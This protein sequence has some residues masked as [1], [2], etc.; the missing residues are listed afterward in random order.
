MFYIIHDDHVGEV[1]RKLLTEKMQQGVRVYFLYDGLGSL[2][3][4]SRYLQE[5]RQAGAHVSSFNE[6]NGVSKYLHINFRNHRKILIIDGLKAFVGSLNLGREYLGEDESMGYWRDTHVMLQGPSVQATQ[7]VFVKDWY[8]SVGEIPE[9]NWLVQRAETVCN[10]TIQDCHKTL[11]TAA[12]CNQ[13]I[14][15]LDTG[16]ADE[17]PACSLFICA[18][19][20]QAKS[21]VWIASPY[22]VPDAEVINALKNAALRGVDIRLIL[23]EKYDKYFVYLT[24]FA[25][26]RELK[27]YNIKI[28]RYTKGFSHQKVILIDDNLAAVGTMNLDNR[29]I[30]LNFEIMAYVAD[31]DFNQQVACMLEYDFK[32]CFMDSIKG[33]EQRPFWFKAISRIFYLLSPVL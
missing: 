25:Y 21:R 14:L 3:L 33:F 19:I 13:N 4:S 9:L 30:H 29:S 27:G 31:S 6:R 7:G 10:S 32:N 26:Y 15:L 2:S 8:W 20:N 22:F 28:Y 23:P 16:P 24:S 12:H 17:K 18:L 11:G 5:L 1:F